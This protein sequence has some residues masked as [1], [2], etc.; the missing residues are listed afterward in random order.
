MIKTNGMCLVVVGFMAVGVLTPS[1]ALALTVNAPETFG[2]GGSPASN[3]W[4]FGQS[5]NVVADAGANG[6]GDHALRYGHQQGFHTLNPAI[7]GAMT[8]FVGDYI[9]AAVTSIRFDA[10]H[11]GTGDTVTLRG[12]LFLPTPSSNNWAIT[13]DTVVLSPS[14]TGW[15][16]Y[17]LSL[18][19]SD[20]SK[21]DAVSN[22]T[23]VLS[24]VAQI[25]LRHDP[26]GT[27]PGTQSRLTS[28]T[29]V[30][31]DNITVVSPVPEPAGAALLWLGL[32]G[33]LAA[34]RRRG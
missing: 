13:N 23:D 12:T 2:D 20:L 5:G 15:Q 4:T 16:T 10:R 7:R 1:T 29:S 28:A 22:V 27:G 26:S 14:D 31:F 30:F 3:S 6:A 24:N 9:T 8:D 17:E 25:G 18:D 21:A 32:A 19:P 11:S 34:G 33:M